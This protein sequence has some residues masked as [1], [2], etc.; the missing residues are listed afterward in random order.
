MLTFKDVTYTYHTKQGETTAVK[1][2][3]FS[4]EDGQFVSVIGPSGCG[5]TTILSIAAGL[6][7]PSSGEVKR[8]TGEFGYMLDLEQCYGQFDYAVQYINNASRRKW[9]AN[10]ADVMVKVYNGADIDSS[11]AQM[12]EITDRYATAE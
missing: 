1:D 9:K 4:V 10:V 12:Q 11:L 2:M 5:K 8:D 6:L 3:N 7:L